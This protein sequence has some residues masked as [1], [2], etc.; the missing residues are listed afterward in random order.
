MRRFYGHAQR[1]MLIQIV[2]VCVLLFA[3]FIA[4]F[5]IERGKL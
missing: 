4:V 2:S 5:F 3:A 1:L